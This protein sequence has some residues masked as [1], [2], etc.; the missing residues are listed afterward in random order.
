MQSDE[1]LRQVLHPWKVDAHLPPR[2]QEQVWRRIERSEAQ[3][4]VPAWVLLWSQL[5]DALARPSLAVN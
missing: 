4:Q 3:A 1:S 5:T 2:F